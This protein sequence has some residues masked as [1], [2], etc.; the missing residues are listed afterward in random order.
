[1]GSM[2]RMA[3]GLA[4]AA[5][6]VVGVLEITKDLGARNVAT[7]VEILNAAGVFVHAFHLEASDYGSPCRRMRSYFLTAAVGAEAIDQTADS[8]IVPSFVG[9]FV[10]CLSSLAIGS[11]KG[12]SVVI[13]RGPPLADDDEVR[14]TISVRVQI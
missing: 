8:F 3:T 7:V 5:R 4:A 12:R 6:P 9:D 1:M 10:R 13:P 2:A 11:G 14:S